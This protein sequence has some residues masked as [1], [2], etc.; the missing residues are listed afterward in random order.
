MTRSDRYATQGV[1]LTLFIVAITSIWAC[2]DTS[3][4]IDPDG[5]AKPDS[6]APKDLE[7]LES[8]RI[9]PKDAVLEVL[10]DKPVVQAY[11]AF[12]I[13]KGGAE[14]EITGAVAFRV[15]DSWIGVFKGATFTSS[16]TGGGQSE[17]LATSPDGKITASTGIT[18]RYK[19]IIVDASFPADKVKGFSDDGKLEQGR[20][21]ELRYPQSGVMIPPN[22]VEL[23]VQWRPGSGNDAFE[24][25]FQNAG[26]DIRVYT[27]CQKVGIGCGYKPSPEAWKTIVSALRGKDAAEITVRG[28]DLATM[29]V[30]GL[31]QLRTMS[32]A[33]EDILGGL[34]YWNATPGN[35]IRY[36]FGKPKPKGTLFYTAQQAGALLCVG[37]HALSRNGKR[38]AVGLDMP[39]PAPLKI[40]EVDTKKQL[41]AGAANFMAFS[42]EGDKIITSDGNSMVLADAATLTPIGPTPLVAKGTMPDWSPDGQTIVYADPAQLLP[43]PFGT[44][45]IEQGSLRLLRW[46]A[47][48]NKWLGPKALVESTGENNYYPTFSPDNQLVIF[49][50]ANG[51]SYDAPDA[52]LWMVKL[53]GKGGAVKLSAANDAEG[54]PGNYGNSW[55]KFAPFVQK[56]KGRKLMWVT[57]SSRRNYGLRLQG[58]DRAQLWMAAID[59]GKAELNADASYPAFWL[60]F[61]DIN[62]GNHIAQWSEKVVRKPCDPEGNCP[63]G[64]FCEDG[65]CEP[66][67]K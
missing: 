12:G 6:G 20:A 5:G 54:V 41:S 45:G 46:D 29:K 22:L 42:P 26:T 61:Q 23:E 15:R 13:F 18:V 59:P 43:I 58:Q 64:E 19:R 35:I 11:K 52:A 21:P 8:I 39:A 65:F 7:G 27:A 66:G 57:F 51:P 17:V 28:T 2:A 4:Y 10:D 37:C 25:R 55:P 3:S 50:R 62:T 40:F 14:H 24:L 60:P 53:E 48:Q 33:Q 34:Y 36:D 32:I 49:N 63:P 67:V 1:L 44:P 38:M 30:F 9:E 56:Y 16:T 47:G 31:S